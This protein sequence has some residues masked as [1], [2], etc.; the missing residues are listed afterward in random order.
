MEAKEIQIVGGELLTPNMPIIPFIA[1]DGIG[2]EIWAAARR[3]FDAAVEKSY[4]NKRKVKWLPV[5]A[6]QKAFDETGEWLPKETLTTLK[7][8]L[9]AIKGPLTTPVGKG[10]RSINVTLRQELDLFACFRPVK[11][12]PGTPSPVKEPEQVDIAVFRENT[13]D[14]YAGIDFAPGSKATQE[15]LTLLQK[16]GLAGRVRFPKTSAFALKPISSEGTKRLVSA[17]ITYALEHDL[18]H[19]TLVHKGNIMKKTEGGFKKWGYEIAESFGNKVYPLTHYERLQEKEGEQ[20]ARVEL[21]AAKKAGK[22]IINDIIA[23]NFF[24]QAL[25]QPAKFDV[26]ATPNLNGDYISDALAAQVG[27]IGISPG[28]NIN[29]QTGQAIFEATHGTAPQFAGLNK[30]N[31]TSLILSGAMMFEY[32]GWKETAKLI[33]QAVADAIAQHYVT[34]D[35]AQ[36]ITGAHELGT[37]EYADYL[38]SKI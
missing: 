7:K 35:F 16:E 30:L 19:V 23:D 33:E 1:G 10:H 21:I 37:S 24:Q 13:E 25:L 20:A 15:L 8:Y 27:G 2:P 14:I 5:L 17:A 34:V 32:I 3:V 38:I 22:V 6:G 9:V 28:A 29:Y 11:Y 12:Y 31:P 18:Q 36:K 26:V 4:A